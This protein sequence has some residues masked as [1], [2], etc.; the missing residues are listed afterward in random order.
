MIQFHHVNGGH[1]RY[2]IV[3]YQS[4]LSDPV[5][6]FAKKAPPSQWK[7]EFFQKQIH[8]DMGHCDLCQWLNEILASLGLTPTT[9]GLSVRDQMVLFVA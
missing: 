1:S 4:F 5:K 7:V 6:V 2:E 9:L 3:R 8:T